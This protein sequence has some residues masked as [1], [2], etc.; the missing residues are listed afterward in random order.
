MFSIVNL[1]RHLNLDADIALQGANSKFET[2]FR[3]MESL[4]AD[5]GCELAGLSSRELETLWAQSKSK[6]SME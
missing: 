2:R 3:A 4:A 5:Q 6:N 1:C